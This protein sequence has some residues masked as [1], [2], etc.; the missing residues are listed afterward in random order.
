MGEVVSQTSGSNPESSEAVKKCRKTG[1]EEVVITKGQNPE[2]RDSRTLR[3]YCT[4][5]KQQKSVRVTELGNGEGLKDAL[6]L[7][8][9]EPQNMCQFFGNLSVSGGSN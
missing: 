1:V 8:Q 4:F 6:D 5:R 9:V 3:L 2:H 7:K